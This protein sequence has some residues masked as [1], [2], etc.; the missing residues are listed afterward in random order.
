MGFGEGF[1]EGFGSGFG[2][3]TRGTVGFGWVGFG[4][5][6]GWVLGCEFFVNWHKLIGGLAISTPPQGAY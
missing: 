5:V 2:S 3:E 6:F 1:G 4:W